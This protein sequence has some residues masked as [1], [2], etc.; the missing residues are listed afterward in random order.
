MERSQ[1][2]VIQAVEALGL[3]YE[4]IR[5]DPAFADT[6]EFCRRYGY[7]PEKSGNT[8]IVASKREPKKYA[9]C[10]VL[11]TTR[12]D[13]NNRT[14]SL[15]GVAKASFATPEEMSAVTGMTA[16][17]VTPFGLPEGIP[18]YVDDRIMSL[19]WV[20]LGGGGRGLK[21]K[22]SPE[23]FKRLDARIISDLA[24]EIPQR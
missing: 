4:A 16:G 15:L 3:P 22:I 7:P 10:V 11:A 2:G 18:L 24:L 13:V 12:L 23:I 14:R 20:I 1:R 9:A 6:A 17:G 5:I 8:I 21:I 19:D